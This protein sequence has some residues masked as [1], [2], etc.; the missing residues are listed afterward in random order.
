MAE[1]YEL[2]GELEIMAPSVNGDYVKY[3]DYKSL[4]D[5][6][7]AMIAEVRHL[8]GLAERLSS[9]DCLPEYHY[10]GMGCG[11]EDR[12]I[13]DRYEAMYHGWDKAMERVA[14]EVLICH[15][16]LETPVTDATLDAMLQERLI[17]FL[18][19]YDT[20]H[21]IASALA[22]YEGL[23]DETLQTVIWVGYPPAPMGDVFS[24]EYV[25]RAWA[26]VK[27]L[28]DLAEGE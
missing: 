6:V 3:D 28:K 22:D 21:K 25:Q 18:K 23:D 20:E 12:G 11:L 17:K 5:R 9:V 26:V 10:Q 1:R 8:R 13:H 27:A 16:D 15:E 19:S 7:T 14:E 4:E 2:V 24:V